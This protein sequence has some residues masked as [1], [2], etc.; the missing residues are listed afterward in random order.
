[1]NWF[2]NQ[3]IGT[4]LQLVF[5]LLSVLTAATGWLSIRT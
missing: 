3:S 5:A 2:R 4:K 1:M